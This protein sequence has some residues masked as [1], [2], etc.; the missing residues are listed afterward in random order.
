[1]TLKNMGCLPPSVFNGGDA[2]PVKSSSASCE[3]LAD[4]LSASDGEVVGRTAP[5]RSEPATEL[6]QTSDRVVL[7]LAALIHLQVST[8]S[9]IVEP[10]ERDILVTRERA[11][12]DRR[13]WQAV[14]TDKDRLQL[15]RGER[16]YA[17]GPRRHV[18]DGVDREDF[19]ALT[20]AVR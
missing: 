19:A 8:V 14:I 9:C 10:L 16:I 5:W 18:L 6:P 3:Q 13:G 11:P 17:D 7:R 20:A 4:P 1:L 12:R 15:R 2:S